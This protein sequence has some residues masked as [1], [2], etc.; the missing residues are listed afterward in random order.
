[1][2]NN[3]KSLYKQIWNIARPF[4]EKG[5]PMDVGHIIWMMNIAPYVCEKERIDDTIFMPLVILHDIGYYGMSNK[6]PF[7]PKV[8]KK[9]MHKGAKIA[10]KI[11]KQLN[12]PPN[13]IKRIEF[14]ISIHDNWAFG[15]QNQDVLLNI[16]KDLDFIWLVSKKG[17]IAVKKILKKNS[18]EMIDYIGKEK[19]NFSSETTKEIYLDY[20]KARKDEM[21]QM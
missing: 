14:Y 12:Y 10:G 15:E 6:N 9:H 11:L 20:I 1:M 8:R 7:D 21:Q 16:F 17:F 5:R 19:F 2:L 13:K 18:K 3:Y 4:Y